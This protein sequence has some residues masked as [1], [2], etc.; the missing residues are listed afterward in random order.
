M[1]K[2]INRLYKNKNIL[3]ANLSNN[4][5]NFSTYDNNNNNNN[6]FVN[7][8]YKNNFKQQKKSENVENLIDDMLNSK[9]NSNQPINKY[10]SYNN[11]TNNS[12][13][14]I[15]SNK[16]SFLRDGMIVTFSAVPRKTESKGYVYFEIKEFSEEMRKDD[17][18]EKR[19]FL[20]NQN[21]ISKFLLLNPKSYVKEN[22]RDLIEFKLRNKY[23][24]IEQTKQNKYLLSIEIN[25]EVDS[26]INKIHSTVELNP[27]DIALFKYYLSN[28]LKKIIPI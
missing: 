21:Q 24:K 25:E 12:E 17:E 2:V 19:N 23:L 10:K 11:T 14:L 5:F 26:Q 18:K 27:E 15:K 20:I 9:S 7:N 6:S 1:R 22:E 3:I 16:V 13:P 28:W 8:Q 4:K